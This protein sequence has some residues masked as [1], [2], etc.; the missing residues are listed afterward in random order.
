MVKKIEVAEAKAQAHRLKEALAELGVT[1]T[2]CT[3]M[4]LVAKSQGYHAWEELE[5]ALS[6]KASRPSKKAAEVEAE[7][8]DIWL[9]W[10]EAELRMCAVDETELDSLAQDDFPR[11]LA[12]VVNQAGMLTQL[13]G[14]LDVLKAANHQDLKAA[15][16]NLLADLSDLLC[17][18]V[19]EPGGPHTPETLPLYI[20]VKSG[21]S[22]VAHLEVDGL[23]WFAQASFEDLSALT[24]DV[25]AKK[26]VLLRAVH[27]LSRQKLFPLVSEQLKELESYLT[28]SCGADQENVQV[29]VID[30]AIA[31]FLRVH[32]G[33]KKDEKAVLIEQL[34]TSGRGLIAA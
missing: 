6:G 12:D 20:Y 11:E 4:S 22:T 5:T 7:N 23:P 18:E 15:K 10:L 34:K 1:V 25:G 33:L 14:R 26:G 31:Q 3:A 24:L 19:R 21:K 9:R 28:P 8:T 13:R 27:W 29:E 32:S 17:L 2:P 30:D 16:T